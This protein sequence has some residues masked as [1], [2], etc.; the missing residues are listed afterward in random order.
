MALFSEPPCPQCGQRLPLRQLWAAADTD[1]NGALRR[2]CGIVCPQCGMR[3]RV[4]Q[5]RASIF[6]ILSLVLSVAIAALLVQQI[7]PYKVK[8][9]RA[10]LTLCVGLPLVFFLN[11]FAPCF[12]RVGEITDQEV[13]EFPLS[14]K[15]VAE[16]P[17]SAEAKGQ[18]ELSEAMDEAQNG[19]PS[20]AASSGWRCASC[21]EEN[22]GEFV[23][24]WKCQ[25]NRPP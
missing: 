14:P 3:L 19:G 1:K 24:C 5:A 4:F 8:D 20:S 9:A 10:I 23:I 21:G 17:E 7:F 13:L 11:R 6:R 18:R 12:A 2:N 15:P 22:P 16:E 25:K